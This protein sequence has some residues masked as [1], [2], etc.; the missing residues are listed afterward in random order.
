MQTTACISYRHHLSEL[1]SA[2]GKQLVESREE[3]LQEV[4]VFARVHNLDTVAHLC[5]KL[6]PLLD[7]CSEGGDS[8]KAVE[9]CVHLVGGGA[10]G[11]RREASAHGPQSFR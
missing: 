4:A 6:L 3:V 2:F 11:Y 7:R 5:D 10:H 9:A 1:G 8:E